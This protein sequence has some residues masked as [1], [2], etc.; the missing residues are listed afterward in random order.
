MKLNI[1]NLMKAMYLN[2]FTLGQDIELQIIATWLHLSGYLLLA[3]KLSPFKLFNAEKHSPHDR[4]PQ[5][6]GLEIPNRKIIYLLKK[7]KTKKEIFQLY[8]ADTRKLTF[9]QYHYGIRTLYGHWIDV[10]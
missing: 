3:I 1:S 2:A 8:L 5:T 9:L 10:E 4:F 7:R 6:Y